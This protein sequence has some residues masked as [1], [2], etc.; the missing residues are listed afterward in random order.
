MAPRVVC[1]FFVAVA[2]AL[3]LSATTAVATANEAS[4]DT[5]MAAIER[6]LAIP[7]KVIAT[8]PEALATKA[9]V[10]ADALAHGGRVRHA[11]IRTRDPNAVNEADVRAVVARAARGA[12]EA[13]ASDGQ[14]PSWPASPTGREATVAEDAGGGAEAAPRPPPAALPATT[15]PTPP[16]TVAFWGA[17]GLIIFYAGVVQ[18]LTDAG[19]LTNETTLAGLS[20]GGLTAV[21]TA[22]GMSGR[23]QAAMAGETVAGCGRACLGA[24]GLG[25][26]VR[27]KLAEVLPPDAADRLNG[28]VHVWATELDPLDGAGRR[29]RARDL[30][31]F[32]SP[33]DVA[34]ALVASITIPCFVTNETATVFRGRPYLDG[35][36]S[37][38]FWDAAA[39]S[40][41]CN[42]GPG[43]GPGSCLKVS[44]RPG[45]LAFGTPS[46]CDVEPGHASFG[47]PF[48]LLN[49]TE[50]RL[51]KACTAYQAPPFLHADYADIC[52]GCRVPLG[53]D[54][55][56][57]ATLSFSPRMVMNAPRAFA[58]GVAEA[59]AWAREYGFL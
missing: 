43:S 22:L 13:L 44:T 45:P 29:G 26:A 17:G 27:D 54:A 38:P 55:C 56:G 37:T 9:A 57:W 6:R 34:G 10:L 41:L 48:P 42:V 33:D 12:A 5:I 50:W 59:R 39:H 52:P 15:K 53:M 31:P 46:A 40:G 11:G 7:G 20:S 16:P 1:G 51:P 47:P 4:P 35:G 25:A 58:A 24:G 21:L 49:L 18:G 30:A 2:A 3:A 23:E 19:V 14:A 32:A 28:R 36:M 8:A